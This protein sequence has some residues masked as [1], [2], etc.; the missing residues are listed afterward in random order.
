MALSLSALS[1]VNPEPPQPN[2]PDDP[3]ALSLSDSANT[4]VSNLR[5]SPIISSSDTNQA[6]T[7][8]PVVHDDPPSNND[9]D[10]VTVELPSSPPITLCTIYVPPSPNDSSHLSLITYLRHLFSS[11]SNP[12]LVMGDF[13]CPDINWDLLSS[14]T[15]LS[16]ALCDLVFDLDI[17]QVINSPT[18][19]K[20][21]LLDLVL[22]NSI[23]RLSDIVIS[24]DIFPLSDHLTLSFSLR[25]HM[26]NVEKPRISDKFLNFAKA[27][28]VGMCDFLLDW[29]FSVCLQSTDVNFVWE[30]IKFAI[31]EAISN[32]VPVSTVT[33]RFHNLPKWFSSNLRN[34]INR[35][36]TLLRRYRSRPSSLLQARVSS[37]RHMLDRDIAS[38]KSSFIDQLLTK[39][40]SNFFSYVRSISKQNQLP[41]KM[42]LNTDNAS[43][44]VGKA[45][46]FNKF[47]HS[48]FSAKPASNSQ[49]SSTSDTALTDIDISISDTF[50]VLSKLDPTKAV[51]IDGISPRLLRACAT[52]LCVPLHHLFNLSL[53]Q[54]SLPSE[55]KVHKITPIYKSGD[56]SSVCNYRPISLL[57]TISKVLEKLIYNAVSEFLV[58]AFSSSQFGFLAGRSTLQQLLVFLADLHQNMENKVMT[59]VIYLDFQKAFDTVPHKV[60]L[61][62]LWSIGIQGNLWNWFYSYLNSRLQTVSINGHLS[63]FLP[64]LSGVPQGSLLGPLLF[65]I[66]INDLPSYVH[67]AKLLLFADDTKC[68]SSSNLSAQLQED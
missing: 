36:R 55:W 1:N 64:V 53:I 43:S 66:F 26:A 13:N 46:L 45:N 10:I 22:T 23:D 20:G 24:P 61:D 59:D 5:P 3:S 27:D 51:G 44:D 39:D 65:L 19:I 41:P 68:Y 17:S 35:H 42:F 50:S 57:C 4:S 25:S 12:T 11:S 67:T 48:V 52:P 18:H 33:K 62:K 60:L 34:Q 15:S 21:N 49:S 8:V 54:A 40:R 7:L 31:N 38:A 28:Y 32:Y 58:E 29:D 47:F 63:S 9:P 56:R 2:S 16:G 14:S 37:S 6:S 30:E